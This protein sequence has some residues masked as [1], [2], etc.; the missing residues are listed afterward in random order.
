MFEDFEVERKEFFSRAKNIIRWGEDLK[1]TK[2]NY[3]T[4]NVDLLSLIDVDAKVVDAGCGGARFK[5][6]FK[7][8]IAFDMVD[9]GSDQD[10]VSTILEADIESNSQDAVL[11]LGVLHSCPQDYHLPNLEKLLSWLKVGGKLVMRHRSTPQMGQN[12]IIKYDW[13][14]QGHWTK[15]YIDDLTKKLNLELE[16]FKED[17]VINKNECDDWETVHSV[18]VWKKL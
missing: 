17:A 11:C 3:I 2:G 15:E 6:Y 12:R 8:M 10:F 14:L 7:N 16:F 13:H 9:F 5:K 4:K 18:W 1:K